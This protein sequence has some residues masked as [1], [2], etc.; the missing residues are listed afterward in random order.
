MGFPDLF[1]L[2]K[3][4]IEA[5]SDRARTPPPL[6]TFEAMFNPQTF[7]RTYQ[8]QYATQNGAASGTQTAT[9][10]HALPASLTLKLLL[11]G[12]N[13]Q[14]MGV[15][16]LFKALDT[17]KD[18]I[19]K[20]LDLTYKVQGS[21]HEP[22]YLIVRWGQLLD[23]SCRLDKVNITYSSFDRDGTPLRAELELSLVADEDPGRQLS[24]TALQSADVSH[25]RVVVAGDTLPLLTRDIYGSSALYLAV[26]RANKLDHF[27]TIEPGREILFPPIDK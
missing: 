14:E 5:Y 1:K 11:D 6:G 19:K 18:R 2:E 10:E 9:F 25:S 27:R 20:F 4:S 17:V 7:D 3:L 16:A 13:V 22:N 12:T 8:N 23:F 26:A 15:T 21:T 24:A